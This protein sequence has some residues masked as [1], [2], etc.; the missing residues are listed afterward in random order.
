MHFAKLLGALIALTISTAIHATE[1]QC[2]LVVVDQ[3]GGLKT[4]EARFVPSAIPEAKYRLT[5]ERWN[6]TNRATS[7]QGGRFQVDRS[8]HGRPVKLAN[9]TVFSS[10]Y[11]KTHIKLRVITLNDELIC[12]GESVVED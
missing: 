11:D 2:R 8:Q 3:D 9:I 5:M 1:S 7:M 10:K 4:V 6:G 12:S